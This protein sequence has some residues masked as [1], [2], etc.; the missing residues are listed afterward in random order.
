[1]RI[2]YSTLFLVFFDLGSSSD[3]ESVS[4]GDLENRIEIEGYFTP[5]E[6]FI[7][8]SVKREDINCMNDFVKIQDNV[9][10]G[11]LSKDT[12]FMA[13]VVPETV[14]YG[15]PVHLWNADTISFKENGKLV[16]TR[17][18]FLT[19]F[20]YYYLTYVELGDCVPTCKV[21][22][23]ALGKASHSTARFTI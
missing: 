19:T 13:E 21:R 7:Y 18:A 22:K 9:W 2:L 3:V 8:N 10:Q 5:G 6:V 20:E 4:C 14:K 11:C 1:M 15:E 12:C 17:F 23:R 16:T